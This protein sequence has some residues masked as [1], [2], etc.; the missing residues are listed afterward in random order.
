LPEGFPA[1][2]RCEL[3][4]QLVEL[5][6]ANGEQTLEVQQLFQALPVAILK[7]IQDR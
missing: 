5:G 3:S 1:Q 2:H 4:G 7:S 6:R